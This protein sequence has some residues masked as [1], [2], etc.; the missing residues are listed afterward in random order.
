MMVIFIPRRISGRSIGLVFLVFLLFLCGMDLCLT[1]AL[2]VTGPTRM[3][4]IDLLGIPAALL[5]GWVLFLSGRQLFRKNSD[6]DEDEE[7]MFSGRGF[8]AWCLFLFL[9]SVL[10]GGG[11][12]GSMAV[13]EESDR[14]FIQANRPQRVPHSN[15]TNSIS[16]RGL[17]VAA[18]EAGMRLSAVFYNAKR[19]SA[20]VNGA[21]VFIGDHVGD[22][23]VSAISPRSVTVQ[24]PKGGTNLLLLDGR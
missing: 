10:V 14:R 21:T 5:A 17:P 22:W 15:Q 4:P 1:G 23:S 20:I 11:F 24:S 16:P 8:S 18:R 2:L 13:K 19:P 6:E 3:E 12:V 9:L 7:G